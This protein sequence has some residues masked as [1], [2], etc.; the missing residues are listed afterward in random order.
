MLFFE[1]VNFVILIL[2]KTIK[3]RNCGKKKRKNMT[4]KSNIYY[5]EY[6]LMGCYPGGKTI[7]PKVKRSAKVKFQGLKY[8]TAIEKE[9]KKIPYVA[10]IADSSWIN[11]ADFLQFRELKQLGKTNQFFNNI[12]KR[13]RVLTK[14]FKN[15][16]YN[17]LNSK[18]A[19][20]T[21]IDLSKFKTDI[22]IKATISS[23]SNENN[24]IM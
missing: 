15:K 3:Y 16:N 5:F 6:I 14:F 17:P 20:I 2:I 13:H 9:E 18:T 23:F 22:E 24:H 1:L 12:S 11:I 10:K 19:L 7:T 4:K 8:N 21:R